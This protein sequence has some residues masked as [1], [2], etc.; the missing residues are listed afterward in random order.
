MGAAAD[1]YAQTHLDML[2]SGWFGG[3]EAFW[4]WVRSDAAL[5]YVQAMKAL[6]EPW[7]AGWDLAGGDDSSDLLDPDHLAALRLQIG[8]DVPEVDAAGGPQAHGD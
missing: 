8:R 1:H 6:R 7:P 5:P 3:G 4:R 2:E